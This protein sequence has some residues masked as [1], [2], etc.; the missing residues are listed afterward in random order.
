MIETHKS[1][2]RLVLGIVGI[3][4]YSEWMVTANTNTPSSRAMTFSTGWIADP[5]FGNNGDYPAEMRASIGA[6]LPVFTEE[7]MN[8]NKGIH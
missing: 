4:I 1:F 5:I 7:E 6:R 2:L 8:L 3:N